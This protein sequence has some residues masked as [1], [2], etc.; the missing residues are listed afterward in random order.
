[1]LQRYFNKVVC[2][3]QKERPDRWQQ[4][5]VEAKRIGLVADRFFSVSHENPFQ[6]FCYSQLDIITLNQ[7]EGS[8]L[9]LEDDVIFKSLSHFDEAFSEL[10]EDWDILY[11]GANVMN[12]LPHSK[13]LRRVLS[14]WTTHAIAYRSRVMQMI[15]TQYKGWE[16]HG[17]YDD[18]LSREIIP[19]CKAYVISPMCAWQRDGRSDMWGSWTSYGWMEMEKRLL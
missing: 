18:W 6:S 19:N 13:H 14:A 17:M 4:F 1:M 12:H 7:H 10:P 16:V 11:L 5:E 3:N 2:L 15:A 9:T 8:V